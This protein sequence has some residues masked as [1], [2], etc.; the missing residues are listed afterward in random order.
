[1][2]QHHIDVF[3]LVL[4]FINVNKM[5]LT[6]FRSVRSDAKMEVTRLRHRCQNREGSETSHLPC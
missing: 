5:R 1:M 6:G 3:L 2:L 4:F